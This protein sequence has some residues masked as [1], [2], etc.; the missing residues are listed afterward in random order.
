MDEAPGAGFFTEGEGEVVFGR[1]RFCAFA[2]FA[3]GAGGDDGLAV[4]T[5]S[6]SSFQVQFVSLNH[7]RWRS[8]NSAR[9]VMRLPFGR[10]RSSAC[11]LVIVFFQRGEVGLDRLH[12]RVEG[13]GEVFVGDRSS[14]SDGRRGEHE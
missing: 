1:R 11:P 7:S 12:V 6:G 8:T 9:V 14:S 3:V 4:V 13:G 2:F 10:M 5:A